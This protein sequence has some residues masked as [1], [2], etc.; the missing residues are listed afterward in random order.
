M[1]F[2][3]QQRSY[4]ALEM[5]GRNFIAPSCEAPAYA[6]DLFARYSL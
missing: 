6:R 5:S 4:K 1:I 3:K 2:V